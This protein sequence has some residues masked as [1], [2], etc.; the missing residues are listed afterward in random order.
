MA[1]FRILFIL[2][3][4]ASWFL[5]LIIAELYKLTNRRAIAVLSLLLGW[6]GV[7]WLAAL[8]IAVGGAIRGTRPEPAERPQPMVPPPGQAYAHGE[9]PAA[10]R[11]PAASRQPG[12]AHLPEPARSPGRTWPSPRFRPPD[13]A[14]PGG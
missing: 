6:S 10:T 14:A 13:D 9:Q 4:L 12:S 11:Q 8:A 7:G 1:L 5:P 3:I 2:A